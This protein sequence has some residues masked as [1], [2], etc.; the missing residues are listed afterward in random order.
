MASPPDSQ[1]MDK[2]TIE[3]IDGSYGQ[4]MVGTKVG[5]QDDNSLEILHQASIANT[6]R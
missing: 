5:R 4:L 2:I 3:S 6:S 1:Q